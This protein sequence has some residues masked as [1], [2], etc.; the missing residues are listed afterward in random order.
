LFLEILNLYNISLNSK[1]K[2]FS[3]IYF[4]EGDIDEILDKILPK[5]LQLSNHKFSSNVIEKCIL[6]T[7]LVNI[8]IFCYFFWCQNFQEYKRKFIKEISQDSIILELMKN[9]YGN[10]VLK[11]CC[12]VAD[13]VE[14]DLLFL[15]ISKNFPFLQNSQYKTVWKEFITN[16]MTFNN[17]NMIKF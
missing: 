12:M 7:N 8:L 6:T 13:A 16:S 5:V 10:F 14:F 15:G 2:F 4:Q 17:Q 9:K 3:K 1:Y 11:K